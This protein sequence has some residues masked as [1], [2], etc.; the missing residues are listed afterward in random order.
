MGKTKIDLN[1]VADRILKMKAS[2]AG[3]PNE[4]LLFAKLVLNV[5][6]ETPVDQIDSKYLHLSKLLDK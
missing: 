6:D 3:K 5:D 1:I 4:Q 2:V